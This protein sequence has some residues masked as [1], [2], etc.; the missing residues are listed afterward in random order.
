[1]NKSLLYII[2]F[3]SVIADTAAQPWSINHQDSTR[4]NFYSIQN[5]FN[6]YWAKFDT[7]PRGKG[8][9]QYKRWEWYW[10][11][12]VFPT[13]LI[14]DITYNISGRE[15]KSKNDRQF[16]S[17]WK[18]M[19]PSTSVGGY[20][21][22]GRV[23]VAKSPTNENII[24]AGAASGGLWKSTDN[25]QTWS[26]NTD[27]FSSLGIS[28]LLIQPN[29]ANI[30]YLATG[31]DDASST[32]SAGVL[33]STNGGQ[34]W[35]TTGLSFQT[36]QLKRIYK[37]IMHPSNFN[38]IYAVGNNGV[39]KTTNGGSTWSNILNGSFYDIKLKPQDPSTV[40][41]AG[42]GFYVST[43]AG[44]SW[45]QYTTGWPSSN[46]TRVAI[47]VTPAAPD[48]VYAI[49]SNSEYGFGGFFM[50]TNS[51]YTWQNRSNTPNILGW[52]P[53]G[54]DAGGQGW[55]DLC[56]AVSPIDANNVYIGGINIW[57]S[58]NAGSTWTLNHHGI[59]LTMLL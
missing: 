16:T 50:S 34:T 28:D 45:E 33:K 32:Y 49:M 46:V 7:I 2:I 20:A 10:E 13:G 17:T 54:T 58:E 3:I 37:L 30:L 56:I 39:D 22:L 8:Y 11:Q 12:R 4:S 47:D 19:G 9:N 25:G 38:I 36:S 40:Y 23:N 35:N 15:S 31:D 52:S 41:V 53:T 14:S 21:G 51:G 48:N 27:E 42:T 6:L 5:N 29:N 24:Y 1:M 44:T 59:R 55:Y 57:H 26:T 18:S 43:D